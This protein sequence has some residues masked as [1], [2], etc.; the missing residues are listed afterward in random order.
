MAPNEIQT[1]LEASLPTIQ[2]H[3][4]GDG[5]KYEVEGVG[6]AFEGLNAVKRQQLVYSALNALIADGTLHAVVIRTF[7]PSEKSGS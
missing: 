5:Y 1:L 6:D 2:W 7:T 3:V 4:D